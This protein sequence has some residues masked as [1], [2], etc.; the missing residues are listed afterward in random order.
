MSKNK[1][2]RFPLWLK[3]LIGA[4]AAGIV[5]VVVLVLVI[6]WDLP[7]VDSLKP[8]QPD[9]ATE[10]YSKE[11]IKIGEFYQQRRFFVPIDEIPATLIHSF[12][13]AEDAEFYDHGGVS[14]MAIGRAFIKNIQAGYKKQGGSTITQQVARALLLS[15]EKKYSRKVKE[16]FLAFFM[17]RFFTKNEILEMYL[18]EVYLGNSAYGVQAAAEVYY[19][20]D[21]SELTIAE[22]A[23]MAGLTKAPSRDNPKKDFEKATGRQQYVLGRLLAES[24]ITQAEYEQALA[25]EIYIEPFSDL[26]A[27]IAPYFV[28]N[29]RTFLMDQYGADR[30]LKEGLQVYTSLRIKAA[31]AGR[32]AVKR[33]IEEIDRRQGYRG[34]LENLTSDQQETF[35]QETLASQKSNPPSGYWKAL[36]ENIDDANG[37]VSIHTGLEQGRIHIS[38]MNWARKPN[39][40]LSSEA[41][42]IKRPSE[43]LSKGDVILVRKNSDALA[44]DIEVPETLKT[45][46]NYELFQVPEVQGALISLDPSTGEIVSMVGGYDFDLSEFNRVLQ[47][48]RQ[49]GSA[50]KPFVYAAALDHGYTPG[51]VINDAPIVYDDPTNEFRWKPKNFS[52]KFYGDTIFRDSLVNS[53]NIPTIKM[54]QDIGI[55]PVIAY[56][57]KMGIASDLQRNFSLALGSSSVSPMELARG[58]A[59]FASGGKRIE[60]FSIIRIIDRHGEIIEENESTSYMTPLLDQ[61]AQLD[62]LEFEAQKV[63]KVA[64]LGKDPLA[65]LPEPYVLT[66]QTSYIMTHLLKEVITSG[67]GRRALALGR[68]AAGKT[69]T[70]NDNLDAWFSGYTPQLVTTVWFGYDDRQPLSYREGGGRTATPVWLDYMKTT[71]EDK[72]V[73]DFDIPPRLVFAQIDADT[74][75]LATDKTERAIFEVF[76][77]GTEPTEYTDRNKRSNQTQ[78]FFMQE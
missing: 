22:M 16:I 77:E 43:A 28:E 50:F 37:W 67:T 7:S 20:K 59:V 1:Q 61:L 73:L 76:R 26:N 29:I 9:V 74:G 14:F 6:A 48:K 49:P 44:S 12:L 72:P 71:L 65:E 47:A 46:T 31:L 32:D 3:G 68:P 24:K 60:P 41:N 8:Y 57:K 23:M 53:R 27:T 18:N 30:V 38:T 62:H 39:T 10:V 15:P 70:T 66:P 45:R 78:E 19:G 64:E 5:A 42:L 54:V 69:G 40:N 2:S 51:S 52:G 13:A 63:R 58:Y 17:E 4:V 25:E 35:I 75:K 56:A 55:D 33:G 11:M 34:P 36:V 21:L